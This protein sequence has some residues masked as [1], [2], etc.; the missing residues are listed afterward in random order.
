MNDATPANNYAYCS[1]IRLED[2]RLLNQ[3]GIRGAHLHVGED[4]AHYGADS[5]SAED[6]DSDTLGDVEDQLDEALNLVGLMLT[7]VCDKSDGLAMQTGAGLKAAEER[8]RKARIRIDEHETCH[9]SLLLAY[10]DLQ[11]ATEREM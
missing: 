6:F 2:E 10:R 1:Q 4:R 7:A 8:L 5:P 11:D 3:A 9:R